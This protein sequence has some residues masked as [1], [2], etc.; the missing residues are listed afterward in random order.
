MIVLYPTNFLYLYIFYIHFSPSIM[1]STSLLKMVTFPE[2]EHTTFD[3]CLAIINSQI[4]DL[5]LSTIE[6]VVHEKRNADQEGYNKVVLIMNELADRVIGQA[7]DGIVTYPFQW[8]DKLLGKR[9]LGVD[10][11]WNCQFMSAE[12]CCEQIKSSVPNP[13]KKENYIEC[14][15]FVPY[16]GMGNP[17][18]SDRVFITVS[19]D[20][21]VHEPPMIS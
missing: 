19:E 2:C 13:D 15:I 12:A 14:H 4:A 11:Q 20:G 16:G 7:D 10:G 8:N 3:D 5:G 18:R 9:T 6:V 21:Y 1:I 17:R